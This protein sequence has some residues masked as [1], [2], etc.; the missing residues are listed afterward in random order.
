VVDNDIP[1]YP[2]E[3]KIG[4]LAS[5]SLL[6]KGLAESKPDGI[7]LTLAGWKRVEEIWNKL[8]SEDQM[9]II[10]MIKALEEHDDKM[11]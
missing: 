9:L 7:V 1:E 5:A 8:S 10:A 3:S 4:L 2:V 11:R 6:V